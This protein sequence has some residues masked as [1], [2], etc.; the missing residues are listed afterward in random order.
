MTLS[1]SKDV[2]LNDP[3]N[4]QRFVLLLGEKLKE[5]K[6]MVFYAKADADLLIVQKAVNSAE[7]TDRVSVGDDTDLLVLLSYHA[8]AEHHKILMVPEPKRNSKRKV[9]NILQLKKD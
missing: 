3:A 7:N 1:I 6:C 9:R 5:S 2:F 8:R 4:K